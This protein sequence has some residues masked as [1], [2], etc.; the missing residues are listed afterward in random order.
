M[1]CEM[2]A[3]L[4]LEGDGMS[5]ERAIGLND[6]MPEDFEMLVHFYNDFEF[7]MPL[8]TS[9]PSGLT[10]LT[11]HKGFLLALPRFNTGIS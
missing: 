6:V 3:T 4:G 7:V 9:L 5:E 1:L 10:R 2:F 11:G 8:Q